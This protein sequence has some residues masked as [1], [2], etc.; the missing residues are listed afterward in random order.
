[1]HRSKQ[2][3]I[4]EVNGFTPQIGHLIA[5]MSITRSL[6]IQE[7]K[8]LSIAQLDFN[9]DDKSNSVGTLLKHMAALETWYQAITFENRDLNEEE[10]EVWKGALPGELNLKLVKGNELRYYLELLENVRLTT[11]RELRKKDDDWFYVKSSSGANNYFK[12]FHVMEDGICHR[13]QIK[14]IKRRLSV[15]IE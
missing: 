14:W 15:Y 8:D 9:L 5:M 7:V 11:I 1:M 13:G 10:R 12:W 3:L 4:T 2:Y 6:T